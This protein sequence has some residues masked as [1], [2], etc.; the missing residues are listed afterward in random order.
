MS[1]FTTM[2]ENVINGAPITVDDIAAAQ[3][4]LDDFNSKSVTAQR[5]DGILAHLRANPTTEFTAA[6]LGEAVGVV[7]QT[8][9]MI[10]GKILKPLIENGT[11]LLNHRLVEDKAVRKY[12]IITE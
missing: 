3:E 6:E 4:A 2:L 11:V 10:V 8:A 7:G 1:K 12:R 9:P 5:R